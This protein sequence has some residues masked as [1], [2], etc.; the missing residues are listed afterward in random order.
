[1]T[2]K[3]LVIVPENAAPPAIIGEA[4]LEQGHSY[5]AIHPI[6]RF[7]SHSESV[8]PAARAGA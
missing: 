2:K 3:F 4:L 5:D 6:D 8:K 1:M 7:A